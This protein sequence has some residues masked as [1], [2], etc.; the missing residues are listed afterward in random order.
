METLKLNQTYC[1]TMGCSASYACVKS[2]G[3]C[4]PRSGV[5]TVPGRIWFTGNMFLT[6]DMRG[7]YSDG[8]AL[9]EAWEKYEARQ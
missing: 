2:N 8:I 5:K 1:D 9:H 7:V 3:E 6:A 4:K